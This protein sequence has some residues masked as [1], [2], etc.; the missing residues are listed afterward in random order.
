MSTHENNESVSV[1]TRSKR[2]KPVVSILMKAASL[3]Y[4]LAV[5]DMTYWG[6]DNFLF[7]NSFA[8]LMVVFAMVRMS[9]GNDESKPE[10]TE[11]DK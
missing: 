9:T 11:T 2:T 1:S 5:L 8:T 7:Y 10:S 4:F 6:G 3:F